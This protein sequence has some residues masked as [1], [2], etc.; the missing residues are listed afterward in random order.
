M[1]NFAGEQFDPNLNLYFNRARYLSTNTG[2]FWTLDTDEG[3]DN[4]PL[5]LHKYLYDQVDPVD[6][7]DPS[8]NQIDEIAAGLDAGMVLDA[9][10][11]LSIGIVRQASDS[12]Q[13]CCRPDV[14]D[15]MKTIWAQT[16]NGSSG[17]EASFTVNG[18][19]AGYNIEPQPYTN[20]RSKQQLKIHPGVTFA[21]FH[22][23]PNAAGPKPSTPG[24]N[25]ENNRY[26]DTGYADM[27]K[28]DVYV[29]SKGGL[30]IYSWERKMDIQYRQ[31]LD[32]T[33]PC[34]EKPLLPPNW[35]NP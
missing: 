23:H 8:G 9:F 12:L 6:N 13:L 11:S 24:N 10:P 31:N 5:S 34:S 15:A 2:R 25:Y 29:V 14:I 17:S 18:S 30:W 3:D 33:K 4:D 16:M 27:F 26:G 22:V 19:L 1:P 35:V 20:E 7:R 32:W 28:Y 21:L